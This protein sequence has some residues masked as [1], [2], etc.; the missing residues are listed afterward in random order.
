[1]KLKAVG[2]GFLMVAS[3][4]CHDG[5]GVL[6]STETMVETRSLKPEGRFALDNVNG[7]ITV[8]TWNEPQVR[9]EADKAATSAAALRDLRVEIEG[10]D[11]RIRVRTRMPKGVFFFGGGGGK[12]D[13]RITVPAGARVRV[14]NVNG[15]VEV[16]AVAGEVHAETTNGNVEVR[17]ASGAVEATSVNG[18]LRVGFAALADGADHKFS[19]VNG[20]ITL[21]LPEGAGGRVEATTVNG[22]VDNDLPFEATEKGSRRR[23]AGRLGKGTGS[24]EA[25]TVNGSIRFKRG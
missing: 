24:L 18:T 23:L 6:S 11:D 15:S 21:S 9:I 7:S 4:G 19:T 22:S 3:L 25:S 12:V 20:S 8:A 1:M 16:T 2:A 5:G 14:E 10:E 13:Y 17:D